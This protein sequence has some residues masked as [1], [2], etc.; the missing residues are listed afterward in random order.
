MRSE[1]SWHSESQGLL[2]GAGPETFGFSL[3]H[4][5]SVIQEK[6]VSG[7]HIP[8]VQNSGQ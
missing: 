2:G 6:G 4:V 5:F 7:F 3:L 1:S 8:I